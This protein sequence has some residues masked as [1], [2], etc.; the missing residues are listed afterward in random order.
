MQPK[1]GRFLR[2]LRAERPFDAAAISW[3][4]AM[5]PHHVR[6]RFCSSAPAFDVVSLA[7]SWPHCWYQMRRHLHKGGVSSALELLLPKRS[8]ALLCSRLFSCDSPASSK[9][10]RQ[11]SVI[12]Y[13]SSA[14]SGAQACF[15]RCQAGEIPSNCRRI[16]LSGAI[17]T[18]IA[19]FVRSTPIGLRIPMSGLFS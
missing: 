10:F 14:L 18:L 12:V 6:T 7:R 3:R 16:C 15:W 9:A 2:I 1:C 13:A 8:I 19:L 17:K 4:A 5:C 11:A